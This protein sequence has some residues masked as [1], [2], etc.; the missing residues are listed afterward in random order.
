MSLLLNGMI[1]TSPQGIHEVS[2]GESLVKEANSQTAPS[3]EKD[4]IDMVV[5]DTDPKE[6]EKIDGRDILRRFLVFT[7]FPEKLMDSMI[8][9]FYEEA[10]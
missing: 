3:V 9:M 10:V 5:E 2:I 1:A 6:E 4:N 7:K 8:E